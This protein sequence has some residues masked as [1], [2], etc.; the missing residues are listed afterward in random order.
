LKTRVTMM[1][2]PNSGKR[3]NSSSTIWCILDVHMVL[4]F[5]F[6]SLQFFLNNPVF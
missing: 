5:I 2:A 4:K 6:E 1:K 3:I